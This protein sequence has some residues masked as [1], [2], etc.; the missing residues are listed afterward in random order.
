MPLLNHLRKKKNTYG[1]STISLLLTIWVA[2][3]LQPCAMAFEINTQEPNH[4][5]ISA[6][7]DETTDKHPCQHCPEEQITK[8]HCQ[9]DDW[10]SQKQT[11]NPSIDINPHFAADILITVLSLTE[12][13]QYKS[14]T[15]QYP[16]LFH[17]DSKQDTPTGKR[18]ILHC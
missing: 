16:S 11:F 4:S 9:F 5:L 17:I 2:L 14:T 13:I 15:Q 1:H 7:L 12:L 3:A 8:D 18:D 6:S 10:F